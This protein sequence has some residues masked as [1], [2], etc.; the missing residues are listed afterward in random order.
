M[1]CSVGGLHYLVR[2]DIMSC[3]APIVESS[4]VE[5]LGFGRRVGS[6]KA[7]NMEF[8]KLGRDSRG[9]GLEFLPKQPGRSL[10]H[11]SLYHRPI[12]STKH[13]PALALPSPKR[14][15]APGQQTRRDGHVPTQVETAGCGHGQVINLPG[16]SR[17]FL[18]IA[19]RL[20]A[21]FSL[22]RSSIRYF[23]IEGRLL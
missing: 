3:R 4:R 2:A 5:R 7:G 20:A 21:G 11:R 15:S 17:L 18:F 12:G 23:L 8:G 10:G 6:Q 14:L 16:L 9:N 1:I 22:H 19:F 13:R